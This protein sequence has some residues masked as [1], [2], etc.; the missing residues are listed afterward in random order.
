MPA[1]WVPSATPWFWWGFSLYSVGSGHRYRFGG[2]TTR[3][4][5]LLGGFWG[6][7]ALLAW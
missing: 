2:D 7:P 1:S 3:A 5:G 4:W 6:F